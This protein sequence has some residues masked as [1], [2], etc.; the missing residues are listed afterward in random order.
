[1]HG[2][3]TNKHRLTR[4]TMARTWGKPPPCLLYYFMC[5]PWGQH[6]NV[7]LSRV[8]QVRVLKFPK[9]GLSRLWRFITSSSNFQ[10]RW[11]LK[12]SCS[13]CQDISN[14]MSHATYMQINPSDSWLLV[15]GSQTVKLTPGPSF[16]YY[17]LRTQMNHASL[18]KHLSSKKFSMI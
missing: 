5:L 1:M 12:Q 3:T 15:V 18:V 11:D 2:R 14:G 13:P 9:L 7:I 17:V 10:S 6:P 16:G 8:S 4:F